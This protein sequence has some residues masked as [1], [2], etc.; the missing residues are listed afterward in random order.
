MTAT[1][2]KRRIVCEGHD[3]SDRTWKRKEIADLS[4]GRLMLSQCL[5]NCWLFVQDHTQEGAVDLKP[6][7][8]VNETS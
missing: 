2:S 4:D 5:K 7:V 6:A 3:P 1:T 8:V